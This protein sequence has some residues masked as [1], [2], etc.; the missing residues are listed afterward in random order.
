VIGVMLPG[1]GT[2]QFWMPLQFRG[3]EELRESWGA[4]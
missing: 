4:L 2:A 1:F 3:L